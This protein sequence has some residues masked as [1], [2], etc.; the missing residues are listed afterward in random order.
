MAVVSNPSDQ[1]T[2]YRLAKLQFE[3]GKLDKALRHAKRLN[4]MNETNKN[5]EQLLLEVQKAID[6]ERLF[7]RE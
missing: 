3:N 4:Q 5:Y 6:T 1:A 2:Q 7:N